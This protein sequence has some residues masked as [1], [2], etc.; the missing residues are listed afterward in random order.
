MFY[1]SVMD[2]GSTANG[3]VDVSVPQLVTVTVNPVNQPP[4]INPIASIT[5]PENTPA[6]AATASIAGGA[7]SAINLTSGGSFYQF[8]P[9]VTIDPPVSG[10]HGDRDA[11]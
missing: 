10:I 11:A 7:V 8:P 3:G 2:N 5:I 1:V 9:T 4:N 6:A